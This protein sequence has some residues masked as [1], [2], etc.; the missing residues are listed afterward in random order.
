MSSGVNVP[1]C[2]NEHV[3]KTFY[4]DD[5]YVANSTK[6]YPYLCPS[7]CS[8]LNGSVSRST[9]DKLRRYAGYEGGSRKIIYSVSYRLTCG[10]FC[11]M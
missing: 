4:P 1:I 7:N 5:P 11:G 8:S 9:R 2:N 6:V 10:A 3:T